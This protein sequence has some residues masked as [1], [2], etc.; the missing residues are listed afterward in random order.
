[1]L[2]HPLYKSL[3]Y[4]TMV[5]IPTVSGA[6]LPRDFCGVCGLYSIGVFV[7]LWQYKGGWVVD[8]KCTLLLFVLTNKIIDLKMQ[9]ET[10]QLCWLPWRRMASKSPNIHH[11]YWAI[12]DI[13]LP[14]YFLTLL[15]SYFQILLLS[16]FPFFSYCRH[17]IEG[18]FPSHF[19]ILLVPYFKSY[20]RHTFYLYSRHTFKSC[21]CHTLTHPPAQNQPPW[22]IFEVNGDTAG[23][24]TEVIFPL[25]LPVIWPVLPSPNLCYLVIAIWRICKFFLGGWLR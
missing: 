11:L 19:Q 15:L 25:V 9:L 21:C 2:V 13:L 17:T 18:L 23:N 3:E 5:G 16:Y 10:Y 1:M 22:Q 24:I 14:M 8:Y 6:Q 7:R 4:V 20:C 12:V